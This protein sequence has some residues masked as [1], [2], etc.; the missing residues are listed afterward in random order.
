M[1]NAWF[2][3]N[4][5]VVGSLAGLALNTVIAAYLQSLRP[6]HRDATLFIQLLWLASVQYGSAAAHD[7][8]ATYWPREI[9]GWV[10]ALVLSCQSLYHLWFAYEIGG[11]CSGRERIPA[12]T[13]FAAVYLTCFAL[14]TAGIALDDL[15]FIPNLLLYPWII[16]IYA[17]RSASAENKS[18]RL[19][20]SGLYTWSFL[21]W[22][23]WLTG[24]LIISGPAIGL[25]VRIEWHYYLLHPVQFGA[26]VWS[27]L[28]FLRYTPQA[29]S[30]Q[31]KLAGLILAA[32]LMFIGL[33]P[34]WLAWLMSAVPGG[35]VV[36]RRMLWGF[37]VFIPVTT[38][39]CVRLLPAFLQ[40]AFLAP[41]NRVTEGVRAVD[42]GEL[43]PPLPVDIHDEIGALTRGF[44]HM[45]TSL[46]THREHLEAL[47]AE[48]TQELEES[49]DT[50]RSTQAELIRKEKLAG[51][52]EVAAGVAH[53]IQ[54]PLNFV[55]NFAG[56]SQELSET[57]RT[58]LPPALH[59][60]SD[61]LSDNL[62]HVV[63]NG[64]RASNI[65]RNMLIHSHQQPEEERYCELNELADHY[66]TLAYEGYRTQHPEFHC[67][68]EK[69]PA[70]DT[71][72]VAAA[73]QD[74]GRVLLNLFS[75][76]FQAVPEK[77]G[78]VRIQ[79]EKTASGVR[80]IVS[81]NGPGVPT[82]L[83][84]KIFQPFFTTRPAGTG[85]GLGLSICHD[86]VSRYGGSI[87]LHRGSLTEMI[88]EL[89]GLS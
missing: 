26:T 33:V 70:P 68:L 1:N 37:V 31:A 18:T 22:L 81:D 46:R 61:E 51:L 2:E 74:L 89:P 58:Y 11:R 7:L 3:V 30:F 5:S 84:E 39:L 76:A 63:D 42:T 4:V 38:I 85:T 82:V 40:R 43:P 32:L 16:R 75:N 62:K 55:V 59:Y 86:I 73:R 54:N 44:N 36:T 78:L 80:L 77:G 48:R 49:L 27:A 15:T 34:V 19:L 67:R 65:V 17:K 28:V 14:F 83:Q 24:N 64:Q 60:L 72:P 9:S 35:E 12:L 47:V 53:E 45:T 52:G 50:L 23:I 57:L 41:L 69:V 13:A 21:L 56:L 66:L 29:T 6:R 25:P 79:T 8:T 10:H 88:I 20:F 71:L 87:R